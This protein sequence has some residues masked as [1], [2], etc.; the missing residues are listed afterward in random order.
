M[1]ALALAG[2]GPASLPSREGKEGSPEA[3]STSGAA[4]QLSRRREGAAAPAHAQ[5]EVG[6][7][8]GRSGLNLS[9][10]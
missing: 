8:R 9:G 10:S 7:N 2:L 6:A 1:R 4:R 5:K 3:A